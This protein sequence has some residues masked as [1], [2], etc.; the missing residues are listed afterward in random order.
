MLLR[1]G[2]DSRAF[3]TINISKGAL[4]CGFFH[5]LIA[6]VPLVNFRAHHYLGLGVLLHCQLVQGKGDML[7]KIHYR[8]WEVG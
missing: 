5:I 2:K 1:K 7:N 3:Q 6:N 4:K 8:G